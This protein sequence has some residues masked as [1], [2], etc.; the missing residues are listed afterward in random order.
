[1]KSS[2]ENFF[3]ILSMNYLFATLLF[4]VLLWADTI[5]KLLSERY[6]E[7]PIILIPDIFSLEYYRNPGIAFSFPL[8]GIALKIITCILIFGII[9]Y[10]LTQEKHK[11]SLSI[12]IAY[13]LV[14][15]GALGNAWERLFRGYVTD[16]LSLEYFAVFNLA[17]S[18]I[19]LWALLLLLFYWKHS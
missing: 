14:L 5:S 16:M 2:L 10:Y 18:Y 8:T 15:A 7:N 3:N 13:I 17:D 12:R 6:L 4:S 11:K 19:T 1:M 9:W